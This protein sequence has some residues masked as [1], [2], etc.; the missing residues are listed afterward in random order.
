M[1]AYV[2]TG[3]FYR[4]TPANLPRSSRPDRRRRVERQEFPRVPGGLV[5]GQAAQRDAADAAEPV[6]A[7]AAGDEHRAAPPPG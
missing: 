6:L 5:R 4:R 2:R 7:G 3:H 1:T